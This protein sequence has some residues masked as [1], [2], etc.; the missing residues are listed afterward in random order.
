MR[1]MSGWFV[2]IW[3]VWAAMDACASWPHNGQYKVWFLPLE[4][5]P[6][7][8]GAEDPCWAAIEWVACNDLMWGATPP[9]STADWAG[10]FK[11]ACHGNDLYF[12]AEAYDDFQ[13]HPP[14]DDV[15]AN[16]MADLAA[17]DG[18]EVF[19][20]LSGRENVELGI[21]SPSQ[22]QF[23]TESAG[24]IQARFVGNVLDK[25]TGHTVALGQYGTREP[26]PESHAAFAYLRDEM[27]Q[28]TFYEIRLRGIAP[29]LALTD[30][31]HESFRFCLAFN[32]FDPGSLTVFQ[33]GWWGSEPAAIWPAVPA[34]D[35]RGIQNTPYW[36]TD[37]WSEAGIATDSDGDGLYNHVESNDGVFQG[38]S[39]TGTDPMRWDSDGDG[40]GDGEEALQGYDPND[41]AD[42]PARLGLK[43]YGLLAA[44]SWWGI[45]HIRRLNCTNRTI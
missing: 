14:V 28:R 12:L 35:N 15:T 34:V 31:G 33:L 29:G 18:I 40:W 7:I 10:R 24:P 36:K 42:H 17:E 4:A 1:A 19:V 39:H 26:I 23:W 20:D 5:A 44:L 3:T 9:G 38:I 27:L 45:Q 13:T 8:D 25:A 37:Y 2:A 30:G 43:Y 6:V 11:A 21:S 32:D 41:P 22:V 16:P